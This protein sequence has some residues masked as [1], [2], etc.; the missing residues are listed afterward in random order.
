MEE[1]YDTFIAAEVEAII[2]ERL[3]ALVQTLEATGLER[4][5][6]LAGLTRG[7]EEIRGGTHA[8]PRMN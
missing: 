1:S 3:A 8:V 5:T 7:L 6:I 2:A 4:R